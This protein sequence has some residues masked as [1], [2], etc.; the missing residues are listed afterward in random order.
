M[1]QP[2]LIFQ[3]IIF[4]IVED[5]DTY[6]QEDDQD[7]DVLEPEPLPMGMAATLNLATMKGKMIHTSLKGA[8]MCTSLKL[9]YLVQDLQNCIP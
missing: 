5:F 9:I 4:S 2:L 3:Y 1:D 7:E 6:F 8:K